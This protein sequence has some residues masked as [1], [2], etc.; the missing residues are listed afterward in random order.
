MVLAARLKS[1]DKAYPLPSGEGGEVLLV[2][3]KPGWVGD[4]G[5][6]ARTCGGGISRAASTA[7]IDIIVLV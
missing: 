5:A 1:L 6:G 3:A 7:C 4:M 2:R